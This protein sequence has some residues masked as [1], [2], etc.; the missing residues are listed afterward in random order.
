M[1]I[2]SK[3]DLDL[4]LDLLYGKFFNFELEQIGHFDLISILIICF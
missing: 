4:F 2:N 1:W 3:M